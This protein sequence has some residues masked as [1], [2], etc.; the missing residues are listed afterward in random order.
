MKRKIIFPSI[1]DS[2]ADGLVAIGGDLETDTLKTAYE[3]GIFPWPY[4]VEFPLA[5]FSP[6]PRGVIDLDELHTSK[7]FKKFLNKT[8]FKVTFNQSFNTVIRSC[9]TMKRKNQAGTWITPDIITS[10]EKLHAEKMAYSVEVWDEI[11]LVGGLYGV[12]MGNFISGES[13]FSIQDNASKLA[14]YSLITHLK[15]INIQ[16]IDT[17]MVTSIVSQFGGKYIPRKHFLERL[18]NIDWTQSFD[19]IF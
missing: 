16:W 1:N 4:S 9:A 15:S 8:N 12:V 3:Q 13:M 7:S 10:Y 19:S 14:L 5:W 17:Q 2:T 18:K 11:H 6:D